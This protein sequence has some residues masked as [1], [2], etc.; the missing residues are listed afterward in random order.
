MMGTPLTRISSSSS[1]SSDAD[2]PRR[3]LS[4][5]DAAAAA[6]MLELRGV[7][8][9][10][11]TLQEAPPFEHTVVTSSSSSNDDE[12]TDE[13]DTELQEESDSPQQPQIDATVTRGRSPRELPLAVV[14]TLRAWLKDH[15]DH[16]YPTM[17]DRY[18]LM[19]AT[20]LDEKQLKNW[21]TNARRRV[22]KSSPNNN[23]AATNT[24]LVN[25]NNNG[26][27]HVASPAASYEPGNMMIT[28]DP[29]VTNN[30][31]CVK[32]K[33]FELICMYH[34]LLI[35]PARGSSDA[36]SPNLDGKVRW[37]NHPTPPTTVVMMIEGLIDRE[38]Q[39]ETAA[40]CVHLSL[41]L[42]AQRY[43]PRG[44]ATSAAAAVQHDHFF[45]IYHEDEHCKGATK[46]K[47]QISGHN[48]THNAA[49]HQEPQQRTII[50]SL[51]HTHDPFFCHHHH[52][53]HQGRASR[54]FPQYCCY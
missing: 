12:D 32:V 52:H 29:R 24:A 15:F 50:H 9:A 42:R 36:A 1:S 35:I 8:A 10:P 46:P 20:G 3:C 39:G 49:T 26:K 27:N 31:P 4:E 53:H 7:A 51:I 2:V 23:N 38:E 13:N 33:V 54:L 18:G 6:S 21:F 45:V 16:P 41:R 37:D 40:L 30:S 34:Y 5:R 28:T 44:R 22:W 48:D 11:S 43:L 47:G 14:A 19:Q 25:S 17:R